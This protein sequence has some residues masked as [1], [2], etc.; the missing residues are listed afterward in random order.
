MKGKEKGKKRLIQVRQCVRQGVEEWA[1]EEEGGE[2]G[3][4]SQ[5]CEYGHKT[6]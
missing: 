6:I 2:E 5:R 4:K 1:M 3:A